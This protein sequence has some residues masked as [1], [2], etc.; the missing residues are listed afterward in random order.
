MWSSNLT[1]IQPNCL[2]SPGTAR[3]G[4]LK[5]HVFGGF[6]PRLFF[7]C[8]LCGK[9][10]SVP[11]FCSGQ[12]GWL[13]RNAGISVAQSLFGWCCRS[14][15]HDWQREW[16]WLIRF[17][18]GCAVYLRAYFV[19]ILWLVCCLVGWLVGWLIDW[20]I[21]WI[22]FS[23]WDCRL[24][25]CG[26]PSW[27]VSCVKMPHMTWPG[28]SWVVSM[29]PAPICACIRAQ[30]CN[31]YWSLMT[32]WGLEAL[33]Q[34]SSGL[35][36]I[37]F[38]EKGQRNPKNSTLLMMMFWWQIAKS[39][40]CHQ[41]VGP[42]VEVLG[43]IPDCLAILET[44]LSCHWAKIWLPL[45]VSGHCWPNS[46]DWY[47]VFHGLKSE[48]KAWCFSPSHKSGLPTI[49]SGRLDRHS[50]LNISEFLQTHAMERGEHF[51]WEWTSQ[52]HE[53]KHLSKH[54]RSSK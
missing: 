16:Q 11:F 39:P 5:V 15:A 33:R 25:H 54:Q 22:F 49:I 40:S 52:E 37:L 3:N 42:F 51:Y 32:A 6:L 2:S 19:Y 8:V 43:I 41:C 26:F 28:E 17:F 7:F 36:D 1:T 21:E 9:I 4:T 44:R 45:E 23:N 30:E 27:W 20:L 48:M 14:D 53:E 18:L 10:W 46:R 47:Q 24:S 31:G 34:R 29:Q 35:L 38:E 50:W 13:D 12:P